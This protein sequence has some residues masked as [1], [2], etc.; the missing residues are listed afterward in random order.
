MK[1]KNTASGLFMLTAALLALCL[2]ACA[3]P[4]PTEQRAQPYIS[5]LMASNK[6]ALCDGSGGFP[7]WLELYN[8]GDEELDLAG[9]SLSDGSHSWV[10]PE[11]TLDSGAYALIFCGGA[12]AE[13]TVSFSLSSDGETVVLKTP[14][15]EVADSFSYSSAQTDESLVRDGEGAV[16]SCAFPTPG[17]ENN[18]AGYAAFQASLPTPDLSI[19]EVLVFNRRYIS[20]DG[21]YYDAV[22]LRNNSDSPVEL[23][24]WYLSDKGGER[25]LYR[26]PER[27]L[28]PGAVYVLTLDDSAPFSLSSTREQLFLTAPDGSLAD[29]AALHDIPCGGAMGRMPGRSGWFYFPSASLGAEN[30]GGARL[31]SEAPAAAEPDGVF[32]G[33][34]SVT[35]AL[36]GRGAI[37]YTL[38][39]S[40]PTT[41]SAL[42]SAPL[43]LKA[44]CVVRA[45]CVERGKLPSSCLDLSYIINEGH[46][47]PV[48]SLVIDPDEM[49]GSKGIY[50]NPTEDW[51]RQGSVAFFD[52][53]ER[54]S[55]SCG[56]KLHGET[57]RVA[58]VKKSYKLNFRDAYGGQLQYDLF[59]NGV[60]EFSSVLL[61]AA[62]ESSFSTNL[63]D[64]VMHEL[65]Q[66]C[67]GAL[68]TQDYRFC[69]LYINGSYW[70]IYA[71]REAHSP[72]H[73]AA[74]YGYNEDEVEMW[75]GK[76][77]VPGDFNDIY[78][79]ALHCDIR[80]EANYAK[81][82]S[83]ID[84]DGL[85]TWA[86]IEA[87]SGNI[88]INSPNVRFYYSE[89]DEVLHYALVDLD[90]GFFA[91]GEAA[92]SLTTGYDFSDL[93]YRLLD[94][95]GFR[96]LYIEKLSEYLHGPLSAENASA[97][98]ARIAA[99][100]RPEVARDG[101]MWGYTL[102]EWERQQHN[103]MYNF[104]NDSGGAGYPV[105]FASTARSFLGMSAAEF[106]KYFGDLS[107]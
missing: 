48:A 99:E 36:S 76:W 2:S 49:F 52:G 12:D 16:V 69:V 67:S 23:G 84:I 73:F 38:D 50:T 18:D 95:P 11:R 15:G 19:N 62:Q 9:W 97:T 70:G 98:L 47:L 63:R 17:F 59:G 75:K 92:Q 8:P 46:S 103:Y 61:R 45:V 89:S 4:E 82:A 107:K 72:A 93:P 6:A 106:D 102:D 51:E 105:Y 104:L 32:D 96:Q 94:N 44:S 13:D 86:I 81:V 24:D 30:S 21:E 41:E 34:R 57:S 87:Y 29:Y 80:D 77:A 28:E 78:E 33:A 37:Y 39:G 100:I 88:D 56:V 20:G 53:D 65:A 79:F 5:E 64:V 14:A 91:Q 22:E 43:R 66:Q 27:R 35:V 7:D 74:H 90:L 68:P 54:F 1:K 58:Q 83:H 26:L 10:F 71:F 31:I 40:S 55:L 60:T 85:I 3:A 25:E 42:Y 101:T